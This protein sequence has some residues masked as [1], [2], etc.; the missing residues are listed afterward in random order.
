VRK[1]DVEGWIKSRQ[2]CNAKVKIKCVMWNEQIDDLT[3]NHSPT[4]FLKQEQMW[5]LDVEGIES[6]SKINLKDES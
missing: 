3:I 2:K 4:P 1:L 5:V 6:S